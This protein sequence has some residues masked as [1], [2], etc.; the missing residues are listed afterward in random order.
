MRLARMTILILF[1][2]V[3][4]V[5]ATEGDPGAGDTPEELAEVT[6]ELTG[7]PNCYYPVNCV[8]SPY[9]TFYW[10]AVPG[11]AL[12]RIVMWKY[13]GGQEQYIYNAYPTGTYAS[14]PPLEP[15][16]LYRWKV[17]GEGPGG[18]DPGPYC[19]GNVGK[20]VYYSPYGCY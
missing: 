7:A 8:S 10:T 9:Q 2:L 3:G 12:Y 1:F 11:A 18:Y 16:T 19:A 17:K 13:V 4:C 15:F 6:S 20:Y 5:P 14:P